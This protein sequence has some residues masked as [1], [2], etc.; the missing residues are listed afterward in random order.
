MKKIKDKKHYKKL[1][2]GFT[3][4]LFF[5][6]VTLSVFTP[7]FKP[8][9]V[10]YS[11]VAKDVYNNSY[12]TVPYAKLNYEN[13]DEYAFYLEKY[14]GIMIQYREFMVWSINGEEAK[15][16]KQT[17]L[18]THS[19]TIEENTIVVRLVTKIDYGSG[20]V[21]PTSTYLSK[22]EEISNYIKL[23]VII[24]FS[25]LIALFLSLNIRAVI[26]FKKKTN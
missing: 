25:I 19:P 11:I 23:G 24:L 26:L 1:I 20:K 18:E 21:L 15:I 7:I 5:C 8:T 12:S 6:V 14:E 10:A 22:I 16:N 2:I 4:P 3:I 17:Y 13:S 9:V